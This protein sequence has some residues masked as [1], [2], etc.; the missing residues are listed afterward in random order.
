MCKLLFFK[1]FVLNIFVVGPVVGPTVGPAVGPASDPAV[2][3]IHSPAVGL[4]VGVRF[5][6]LYI[7]KDKYGKQILRTN[8]IIYKKW[9]YI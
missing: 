5:I 2:G 6:K 1:Y 9:I 3:P 4:T 8:N 7:Y